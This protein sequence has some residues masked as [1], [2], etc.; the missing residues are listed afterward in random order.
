MDLL[1]YGLLTITRKLGAHYKEKVGNT[2]VFTEDVLAICLPFGNNFNEC[3][4][5]KFYKNVYYFSIVRILSND[6]GIGIICAYNSID[7]IVNDKFEGLRKLLT[8]S[9]SK[10]NYSPR[11]LLQL[12]NSTVDWNFFTQIEN[13][14]KGIIALLLNKKIYVIDINFQ[15]SFLIIDL[16]HLIPSKFH[17][18]LDFTINSISLTENVTIQS[19]QY[20][21]LIESQITNQE[22]ITIID[23]INKTCFGIY[24]SPIFS[25]IAR[26]IKEN[27]VDEA[28]SIFSSIEKS[29]TDDT[30]FHIEPTNFPK[31]IKLTKG[32]IKLLEKIKIQEL[33]LPVQ[34]NL[35]EELIK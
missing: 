12:M 1:T 7:E 17:K 28:K 14:E 19:L 29:I 15:F 4:K 34:R 35:F 8:V 11:Y 18:F 32:D 25:L 5:M 22:S 27:N 9:Q 31:S 6:E 2:E 10:L 24:S 26:K 33:N 16:I 3:T 21:N 23:L 30:S 20:E 13:I